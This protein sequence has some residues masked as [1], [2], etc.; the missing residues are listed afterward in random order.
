MKLLNRTTY[1]YLILSVPIILITMVF[2]YFLIRDFNQNHVES[3]L[4]IEREKILS[5]PQRIAHYKIEDELSDE[6]IVEEISRDSIITDVFSTI[7]LYNK[8]EKDLEP[9]RQLETTQVIAGKNYRILIRKSLVENSTLIYSISIAM[10]VLTLVL[11]G[12]LILLNRILSKRLWSPFYTILTSLTNY[13]VGQNFVTQNDLLTNEFIVLSNSI[14]RMT[15]R[16]N[17]EFFIQKEFIDILSHEYQTPLT[18]I[19]NEAEMLLQDEH[20]TEKR[21][22][23]INQIIE[24]VHKLSKLNQSLLLLSRID[25][26]QFN[27]KEIIDISL[28]TSLLLADKQDQFEAK[29]TYVKATNHETCFLEIDKT[30]AIILIEN[31]LQN[32]IRHNLKVN[33]AIYFDFHAKQ[34]R[35]SNTGRKTNLTEKEMFQKFKKDGNSKHSIGL[36]LN[37]VKAICNHYNYKISYEF[38]EMHTIHTFVI[39][40]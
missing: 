38:N 7:L 4:K 33:S 28:L 32:A 3:N 20:L 12:S 35:V 36:G 26:Q 22:V 29:G 25:N 24:S 8:L 34:I 16:I 13:H 1:T 19:G 18:V 17:K 14:K 9:F 27:K 10:F 31:L 21:A 2:I 15:T 5:K 39:N 6:L 40:T 11:S 30:L 37:I 23:K